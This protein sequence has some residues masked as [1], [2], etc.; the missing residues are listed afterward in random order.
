[1]TAILGAGGTTMR[2]GF[3]ALGALTA[4][5][6]TVGMMVGACSARRPAE[7]AIAAVHSD[8]LRERMADL[9]GLAIDDLGDAVRARTTRAELARIGAE[10]GAT[11]TRLPDL[12]GR[13]DLDEDQRSDFVTFADALRASALRL[14]EAAP[15]APPEELR[16]RIEDVTDACAGCHWAFRVAPEAAGG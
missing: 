7:P 12:V 13:F 11:A 5:G 15:T 16:T 8:P 1:M 14:E 10:L 3:V 6:A 9:R 4:L 2:A